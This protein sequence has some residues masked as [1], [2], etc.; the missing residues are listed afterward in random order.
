[1][2]SPTTQ[3][4]PTAPGHLQHHARGLHLAGF[5]VDLI[6]GK[7]AAVPN[8]ARPGPRKLEQRVAFNDQCALVART[9]Y[10]L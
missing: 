5:N 6:P 2:Q 10:P 1:M 7:T 4:S 3:T 9:T 8:V